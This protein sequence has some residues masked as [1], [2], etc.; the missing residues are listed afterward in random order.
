MNQK[1]QELFELIR[2]GDKN[3]S[4]KLNLFLS[5]L[6]G[7]SGEITRIYHKY[8]VGEDDQDEINARIREVLYTN[9]VVHERNY[10][11]AD[12]KEDINLK[13]YLKK[14][15]Y[16]LIQEF[17]RLTTKSRTELAQQVKRDVVAGKSYNATEVDDGYDKDPEED[18]YMSEFYNEDIDVSE[19]DSEIEY[20][21]FYKELFEK[22]PASKCKQLFEL[23]F[24]DSDPDQ[25]IKEMRS[26]GIVII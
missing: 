13:W 25:I 10:K 3:A 1:P 22:L 6:M 17:F 11:I 24:Q 12:I 20:F 21:Q 7:R 2:G 8:R 5:I 14:V 15:A 4:F 26:L 19:V 23:I 16:N 9:I 18:K